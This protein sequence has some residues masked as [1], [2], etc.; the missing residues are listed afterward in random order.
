MSEKIVSLRV[1]ALVGVLSGA[2][3]AFWYVRGEVS[4]QTYK[5]QDIGFDYI[6]Q[7]SST[8]CP[9]AD[10]ISKNAATAGITESDIDALEQLNQQNGGIVAEPVVRERTPD[11][12]VIYESRA[13]Q[14]MIITDV[15]VVGCSSFGSEI[16][17]G[18]VTYIGGPLDNQKK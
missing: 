3:L 7:T 16:P 8:G 10:E 1:V 4:A 5:E 6:E 11:G 14:T 9:S 13:V 17:E 15:G 18:E 12:E 2:V